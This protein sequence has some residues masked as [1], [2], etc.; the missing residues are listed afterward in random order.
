MKNAFRV[1]KQKIK[2]IKDK[3][4]LLSD[5]VV[6]TGATSASCSEALFEAGCKSV[7]IVSIARD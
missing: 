4:I 3:R 5:D 2:D 7:S 1:N 6:T